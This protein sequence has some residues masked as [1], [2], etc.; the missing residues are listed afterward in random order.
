[1][2]IYDF[3]DKTNFWPIQSKPTTLSCLMHWWQVLLWWSLCQWNEIRYDYVKF[4]A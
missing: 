3:R 2:Y 1:M 4:I